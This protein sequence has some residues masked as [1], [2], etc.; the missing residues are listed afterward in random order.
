LIDGSAALL[1]YYMAAYKITGSGD[2]AGA[3]V[4]LNFTIFYLFHYTRIK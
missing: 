4:A 2:F 3:N 1:R